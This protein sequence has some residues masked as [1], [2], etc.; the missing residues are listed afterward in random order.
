MRQETKY[1]PRTLSWQSYLRRL[2]PLTTVTLQGGLLYRVLSFWGPVC[3]LSFYSSQLRNSN[4]SSASSPE[5]LHS[6]LSNWFLYK[7]LLLILSWFECTVF[8]AG[9]LTDMEW[10]HKW[11]LNLLPEQI[12]KGW[13]RLQRWRLQEGRV[14]VGEGINLFWQITWAT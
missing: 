8:P 7:E 13:Y 10:N 6:H 1:L 5:F 12:G 14:R 9:I 4:S 11:H 3:S 2:C